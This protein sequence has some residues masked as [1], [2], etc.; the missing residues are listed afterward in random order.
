MVRRINERLYTSCND[1]GW[2]TIPEVMEDLRLSY[3]AEGA[4]SS[5]GLERPSEE[6]GD[7]LGVV[8]VR[9]RKAATVHPMR[10]SSSSR[11]SLRW[12]R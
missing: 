2:R 10:G 5:H 6:V 8:G 12:K 9:G 11:G 7:W 3:V 4:Q 1:W